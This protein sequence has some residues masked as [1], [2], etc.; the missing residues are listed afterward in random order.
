M[1]YELRTY[2]LKPGAVPEFEKLFEKGLEVR[3]KYSRLVGFWHTEIGPVNQVLHLWSYETLQERAD[4]RAAAAKDPSGL[5]PPPGV[6][7]LTVTM[8]N[9]ILLP[10]E[11][12]DPL[13]GPREWGNLYELRMYTYPSGAN[14][15][16]MQQM[17]EQVGPRRELSPLGGFF[18]SDLGELNRFYQLW[19][20]KDWA[21]RDEMRANYLNSGVWP[22]K[23]DV[24]PDHQLVR[25]LVPASFSALH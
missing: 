5:W 14:R 21:H 24:R 11:V 2:R 1:L 12:N 13:D 10:S 25:H 22:A 8:D 17:S 23:V 3:E 18:V 9:D 7:D 6:R 4:V 20:Y 19:P 16:V 15:S